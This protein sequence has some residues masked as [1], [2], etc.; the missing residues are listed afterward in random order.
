MNASV[1]HGAAEPHELVRP[2]VDA[3][4]ELAGERV[5]HPADATPSHATIDVGAATSARDL[6]VVLELDADAELLRARLQDVEQRL[7]LEAAEAVAGRAEDLAAE[8][9]SMSSQRANCAVICAWVSGSAAARWPSVA[10][11]NTTPKPNVSS[12]RLRS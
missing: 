7:A 4:L 10:S 2:H 1:R 3:R 6:I 12:G 9:I 11:E 5:A 8:W